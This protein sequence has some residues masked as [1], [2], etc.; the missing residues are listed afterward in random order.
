MAGP[1]LGIGLLGL[2]IHG[3]RYARHL[4]EGHVEGLKLNA[5]WTRSEAKGREVARSFGVPWSADPETLVRRPD[6]DAVVIV[7]PV[8]LHVELVEVCA[9]A[10]RPILIEKPL[11][12]TRADGAAILRFVESAKVPLSV[13]QTLRFDPLLLRLRS[14]SRDLGLGALRGFSFEQRLE[15][16]GV[17]WEDAPELSGGGVLIQTGI[18]TVDALRFLIEPTAV[19]VREGFRDRIRYR[20]CED[21]AFLALALSGGLAGDGDVF[22]TIASSKLGRSRHHRY[23]LF[24]DDGGLEADFVL[25][26]LETTHGRDRQVEHVPPEPTIARTLEAFAR[27]LVGRG[28]NPVTGAEAL[29]AVAIVE[30]G[31]EAMDARPDGGYSRSRGPYPFGAA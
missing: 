27:F 24:F 31:Y 7:V 12:A 8:G 26:T 10:G 16:R 28:P 22:G 20:Q 15:P 19:R 18:H 29:E 9:A 25:R 17:A 21:V 23:Q 5:V 13:A 14:A 3:I 30:R 1:S 11:C 4:A 2:G 6:V